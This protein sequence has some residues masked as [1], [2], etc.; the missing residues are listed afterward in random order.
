M[1]T[2]VLI[3]DDEIKLRGLLARLLRLENYEVSE[4]GD[5]ETG[6]KLLTQQSFPVVL[7]DV[8]LPDGNGV[9]LTKTIKLQYPHTEVILLTAFGNIPDGVRAIKNGA[10]DYLVKGDDN[11]R[12]LT[13]LA[14]ASEKALLKNQHSPVQ[15][16]ENHGF[17]AIIGQSVPLKKAIELAQKVAP[18]DA[19]ILLTGETGTGKDVFAQAIHSASKRKDQAFVALNCA[20]FSR[21]IIESELF[22]HKAGAFTG[23]LKDKKG[24]LEEAHQGTLFLDEIGEMPLE[25]QTKLLRVLENGEYLKV[26]STKTQ[27]VD[28]RIIATTNRNLEQESSAGHFRL[29]LFYR[30]ATF[31]IHLPSL[32]ERVED[33]PLLAAHFI[34]QFSKKLGKK[35]TGM[36]AHFSDLLQQ[37]HW[38][39][40]IRELRN[41]LERACILSE[42][43]LLEVENLPWD[44]HQ[45]LNH[46][47]EGL[48]SLRDME[49]RHISRMLEHTHGNKTRA[50]ELLGIGLTTLYAKIKEFN[51]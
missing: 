9:E 8:K 35:I 5:C 26:G 14:Q 21:E 39:G 29:D 43:A 15:L 24:L 3:I 34:S 25:L 20:A 7:C 51:L 32:N 2:S 40:N 48:L 16:Q 41:V 45:N 6:L 1:K 13:L 19:S 12:I 17:S 28:V 36:Q 30:L 27:K 10:F 4:A 49:K 22:G 47:S 42:K 11:N 46:S 31:S 33:I 44:F 23:A 50:A 37:H 18:T 38:R